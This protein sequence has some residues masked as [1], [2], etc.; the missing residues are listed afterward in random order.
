MNPYDTDTRRDPADRALNIEDFQTVY[1]FWAYR[2]GWMGRRV[3][4]LDRGR[5]MRGGQHQVL[6]LMQALRRYRIE[7]LLLARRGGPLG[8]AALELGFPVEPLD[9]GAL[10]HYNAWAEIVHAHDAD[11]HLRATIADC[12]PLVVA[13]RVAFPIARSVL[14]RWKYRN[15]DRYVAV[16]RHVASVLV[17]NGVPEENVRVVYDGVPTLPEPALRRDVVALASSDPGKC[18]AL[19]REAAALG[20]FEVHF[21]QN[22]P[23]A[24]QTARIFLYLSWAEGFGSAAVLAMSAGIPV[25]ASRLPAM[26]E[27][28]AEHKPGILVDNDAAAVAAAVRQLLDHPELAAEYG[29]AG[30]RHVAPRFSVDRMMADTLAVYEELW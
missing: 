9:V 28:F 27:I 5:E 19:I 4:H 15:A 14:S 12:S 20:G 24:F 25:V 16:S 30:R 13:R 3:L 1:E 8:Q 18:N 2:N 10:P 7:Q 6:L 11:S 26:E 21:S 29:A 17:E 22:L 23:E